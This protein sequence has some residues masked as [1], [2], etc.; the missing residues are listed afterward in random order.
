MRSSPRA[1]TCRSCEKRKLTGDFE[2]PYDP[3]A[4]SSAG[5]AVG[6]VGE[7]SLRDDFRILS[8]K[9]GFPAMQDSILVLEHREGISDAVSRAMSSAIRGAFG[10]G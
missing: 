3:P 10:K 1:T 4:K 7:N 6:M 5:G 8:A 9:D 2:Q